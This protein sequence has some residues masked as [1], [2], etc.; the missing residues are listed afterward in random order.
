[1]FAFIFELQTAPGGVPVASFGGI[2]SQATAGSPRA[3]FLAG[4]LRKL[5]PGTLF[6]D[7]LHQQLNGDEDKEEMLAPTQVDEGENGRDEEDDLRGDAAP[8]EIIDGGF[9]EIFFY[10]PMF[11]AGIPPHR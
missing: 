6:I 7:A 1:M 3:F 10:Q 9:W 4:C 11:V 5:C 8:E 2:F